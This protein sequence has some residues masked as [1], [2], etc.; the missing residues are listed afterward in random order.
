MQIL[1]TLLAWVRKIIDALKWLMRLVG[2][3]A[4]RPTPDTPG[5]PSPDAAGSASESVPA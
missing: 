5:S 3:P 4:R 2:G 1:N